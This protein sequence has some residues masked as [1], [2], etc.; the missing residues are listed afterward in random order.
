MWQN[1]ELTFSVRPFDWLRLEAKRSWAAA[2]IVVGPFD[3]GIQ[4]GA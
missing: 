1:L 3:L 4:W 2:W